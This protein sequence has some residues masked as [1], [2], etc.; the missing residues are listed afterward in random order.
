MLP[1]SKS[2][3]TSEA[4]SFESKSYHV[5]HPER[6]TAV[7]HALIGPPNF[8]QVIWLVCRPSP[9]PAVF[10]TM[11]ALVLRRTSIALGQDRDCLGNQKTNLN[12][13]V[14]IHQILDHPIIRLAPKLGI[15]TLGVQDKA[16]RLCCSSGCIHV[17]PC[18]CHQHGDGHPLGFPSRQ[19]CSR[20]SNS[21]Y[22]HWWIH[23]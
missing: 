13:I 2:L 23:M 21:W 8:P 14:F 17:F 11:Y 16:L 5:H 12:N 9:S 1:Y 10:L 6:W 22:C 4:T 18:N 20:E 3:R 7:A 19:G 15:V